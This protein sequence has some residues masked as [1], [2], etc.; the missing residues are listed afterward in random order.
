MSNYLFFL[1]PPLAIAAFVGFFSLVVKGLAMAGW[2]RLAKH[3]QV[4]SVPP[5]AVFRLGHATVG[6]IRYRG[7]VKAGAT[8][9][10]LSLATG[11][12][13]GAGHQPMLIPWS[14]IGPAR[15]KQQLWLTSYETQVQTPTGS[16]SLTFASNDLAEAAKPWLKLA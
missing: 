4:A 8:S 12:P 3:Y 7:A 6:G 10:G 1:I 16:V 5:G 15:V 14:A 2:Q 11:F 13:F 9:E